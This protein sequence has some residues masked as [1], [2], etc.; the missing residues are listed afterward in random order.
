[1]ALAKNALERYLNS[2]DEHLTLMHVPTSDKH[3]E[4]LDDDF[5]LQVRWAGMALG[6]GGL[7]RGMMH[8]LFTYGLVHVLALC[9]PPITLLE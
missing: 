6:C 4:I 5:R 1:M 3:G 2:A 9:S 7:E 8:V